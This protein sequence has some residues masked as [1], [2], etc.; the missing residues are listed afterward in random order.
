MILP[1]KKLIRS[2]CRKFGSP[3]KNKGENNHP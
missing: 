3:N 2:Y 1:I